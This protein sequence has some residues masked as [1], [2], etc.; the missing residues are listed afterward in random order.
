M[1]KNQVEIIFEEIMTENYKLQNH[2]LK[3]PNKS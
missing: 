3:K 2:K 1:K